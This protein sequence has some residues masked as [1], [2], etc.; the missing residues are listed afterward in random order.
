VKYFQHSIIAIFLFMLFNDAYACRCKR[1]SIEESLRIAKY[2]F[3]GKVNKIQ[4]V[5]SE[6]KHGLKSLL[7]TFN[8]I[9]NLK[10]RL[11][12]IV[13]IRTGTGGGDCGLPFKTGEKYLVF[14]TTQTGEGA[15]FLFDQYFDTEL[16]SDR[17]TRTCPLSKSQHDVTLIKKLEPQK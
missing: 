13:N 4:V 3:I 11:P 2:V 17:C 10:G 5:E 14:T 1:P 6:K 12:T 8:V 9:D 15:Y 7:A 16:Y